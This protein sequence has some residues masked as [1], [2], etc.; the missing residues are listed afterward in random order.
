[1]STLREKNVLVES[2]KFFEDKRSVI[3]GYPLEGCDSSTSFLSTDYRLQAKTLI[4]YGR[5]IQILISNKHLGFGY[6]GLVLFCSNHY[7]MEDMDK[8]L[9]APKHTGR[10]D[11]NFPHISKCYC[12]FG[13]P[14]EDGYRAV[15]GVK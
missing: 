8:E 15:M 1:M 10:F 14:Y 7:L 6:K 5:N 3:K 13:L 2:T 4:L 11:S 12:K 9:T